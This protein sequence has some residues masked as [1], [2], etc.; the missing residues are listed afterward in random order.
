MI[1]NIIIIFWLHF[2]GDFLLQTKYMSLNK[3]KKIKVLTW[4][5]IV[6]SLPFFSFSWI[7]SFWFGYKYAILA[8]L[9]HFPIDYITS[10]VTSKLYEINEIK[11]FFT[12][13]GLDQAIH[14]TI[15]FLTLTW[16]LG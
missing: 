13:I 14:M 9:L 10:K 16:L 12:V 3:S 11:W 1:N 2:I 5:C 15:L 7:Y 8:G 4:H 6:Y